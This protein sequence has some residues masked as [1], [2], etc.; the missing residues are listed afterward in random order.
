MA[1]INKVVLVGRLTRD[2]EQSYTPGGLAL[3]KFG[4][5]VNRSR[6]QGDEWV[7]EANFFD[8]TVY[9]RQGEAIARYM[10]K[11]K[12][13][14]VDGRLRQDRWESQDG[15]R[16]SKVTIDADNVQLLGGRE[17]R[18]GMGPQSGPPGPGG[19]GYQSGSWNQGSGQGGGAPNTALPPGGARQDQAPPAGPAPAG[20]EDDIPF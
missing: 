12:Q 10:T 18:E 13:V 6:K 7:D 19:G 8:I 9:G 17:D 1:E 4:I 16:R 5:A 2:A 3:L 14:A 20:F 11:G 15:S